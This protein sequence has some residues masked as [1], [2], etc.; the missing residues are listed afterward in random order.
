MAYCCL[1]GFAYLLY[2][3]LI[4]SSGKHL[5]I[6]GVLFLFTII[7]WLMAE[8]TYLSQQYNNLINR[9][10]DLNSTKTP[11]PPDIWIKLT[12]GLKYNPN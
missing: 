5:A 11:E 7:F 6:G 12:K 9:I 4:L 8:L 10:Y 1:G 3:A 2:L